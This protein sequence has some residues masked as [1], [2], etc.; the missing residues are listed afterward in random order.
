MMLNL[1]DQKLLHLSLVHRVLSQ[2]N[3][4]FFIIHMTIQYEDVGDKFSLPTM[5]QV[6]IQ[7][8]TCQWSQYPNLN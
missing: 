6:K 5:V 7:L 3:I 2:Y 8:K 4:L 1:G